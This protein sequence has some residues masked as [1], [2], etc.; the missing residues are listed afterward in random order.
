[1]NGCQSSQFGACCEY[2]LTPGS[3]HG[4]FAVVSAITAK[5]CHR[6]TAFY[7]SDAALSILYD[8]GMIFPKN[9]NFCSS[10]VSVCSSVVMLVMLQHT[11]CFTTASLPHQTKLV[12]AVCTLEIW[13]RCR[14][15]LSDAESKCRDCIELDRRSAAD[16]EV[17]EGVAVTQDGSNS[18]LE[19]SVMQSADCGSRRESLLHDDR[20]Q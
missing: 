8:N 17:Q 20:T 4:C 16:S 7:F 15:Q 18:N 19:T 13:T 14:C 3:Q 11:C 1:M 12:V 9:V 5:P 10:N 6:L 2:S